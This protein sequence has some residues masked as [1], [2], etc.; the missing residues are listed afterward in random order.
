ME[1]TEWTIGRGIA[2]AGKWIAIAIIITILFTTVV[3]FI[4]DGLGYDCYERG[5]AKPIGGETDEYGCL[6][7]TGYTWNETQQVCVREWEK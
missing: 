4:G 3:D 6:V 1:K 2:V 7:A 5:L